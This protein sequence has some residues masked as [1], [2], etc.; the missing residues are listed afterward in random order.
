VAKAALTTRAKALPLGCRA[1]RCKACN[2]KRR[3]DSVAHRKAVASSKP[4]EAGLVA[5]GLAAGTIGLAAAIGSE[6]DAGSVSY[7]TGAT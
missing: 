5:A 2:K 6:E 3:I 4:V 1:L 7:A